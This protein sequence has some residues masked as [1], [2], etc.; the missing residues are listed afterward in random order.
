[1]E[2]TTLRRLITRLAI[3]CILVLA[4]V[5]LR[6][7][8]VNACSSFYSCESNCSYTQWL[9]TIECTSWSGEQ[10]SQCTDACDMAYFSCFGRCIDQCV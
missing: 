10:Y 9:C 8:Q 2:G 3:L 4:F 7:K 1:M 6:P 5:G